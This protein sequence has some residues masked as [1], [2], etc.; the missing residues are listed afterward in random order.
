M[1]IQPISHVPTTHYAHIPYLQGKV[2][3]CT[4]SNGSG[5]ESPCGNTSIKKA[6]KYLWSVNENWDNIINYPERVR[7]GNHRWGNMQDNGIPPPNQTYQQI[8]SITMD[9]I[10]WKWD[11]KLSARRWWMHKIHRHNILH[12]TRGYAVGPKSDLWPHCGGLL[13]TEL[14]LIPYM[15][16]TGR[17]FNQLPQKC[18]NSHRR[19]AY[20]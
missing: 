19:H 14:R 10:V 20:I 16:H 4:I 5:T 7:T 2:T 17:K 6:P 1:N 18:W 15:P 13:T 9:K 3:C 8:N 12:Q 11:W